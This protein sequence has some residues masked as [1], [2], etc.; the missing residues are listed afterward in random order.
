M[1]TIR[2]LPILA[3]IP[4][5]GTWFLRY[6]LAFLAHL[7]RGGRID[8]RLT[9][10]IVGDPSGAPFDFEQFNGGPIFCVRG[11]MPSDHVFVGHTV[12]PGF[13]GAISKRSWWHRSTFHVPGYDYL[14]EGLNYRYT[15]VEP[16]PI[17]MQRS[18]SRPWNAPP[19]KVAAPASRWSFEIL[20]TR[21]RRTIGTAKIT[22]TQRT[23]R[24]PA[25]ACRGFPS[26]NTC[27]D[28]PCVPTPSSSFPISRWRCD[29]RCWS[30]CFPMRGSCAI[31]CVA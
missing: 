11:T 13:T 19:A 2:S 6:A 3:T 12:C 24:S 7:D 20:S 16:R 21:R 29:T 31:R 5:S 28:W 14:H 4:R 25:A 10:R 27:S 30:G 22:K 8:N 9:G 18:V 17:D 23:I 26:T 1:R 15:P